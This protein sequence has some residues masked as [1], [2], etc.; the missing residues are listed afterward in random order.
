MLGLMSG[1]SLDGLDLCLAEFLFSDQV[2]KF[3]IFDF[4]TIPYTE[5]WKQKL[6]T[7]HSLEAEDLSH[8]DRLY[9]RW[10]GE[11]SV[12][13]L[14]DKPVDLIASHGHTIFHQ[15]ARGFTLQIGHGGVLHT[16][17]GIP[18]VND[19]RSE[20]VADGG[21]GAPLVPVG[22]ALLF[23]AYAACLNLGG[24]SNISWETQHGQRLAGDLVPINLV[25]SEILKPL[26]IDFDSEGQ[27]SLTGNVDSSVLKELNALPMMQR[28]FPRSFGREDL[29]AEVFPVLLRHSLS[30]PDTLATSR[31]WMAGNISRH[32]NLNGIKSCLLSGGGSY[33]TA[34]VQSIQEKTTCT[35]A[36]PSAQLVEAKEALIFGFLGLLRALGEVN[37]WHEVTGSRCSGSRGSL[38]GA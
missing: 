19:F 1:T 17:T 34:L 31:E 23:G 28:A 16:T 32:L 14:S 33:N 24:F 10:L 9:G 27:L 3:Q 11:Q 13:F 18:V 5:T 26:N 35:L 38:W 37:V 21:Q 7:A 15:P 2:W 12:A 22:D 8:L 25:F 6:A 4:Q 20:D 29:E 30:I 36:I